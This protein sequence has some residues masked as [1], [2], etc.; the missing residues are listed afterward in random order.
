MSKFVS[1]QQILSERGVALVSARIHEMG[2][3]WRASA[4]SD[5]GIDGHVEL[6]DPG[7]GAATNEL[8]LV[9]VKSTKKPANETA[10]TFDLR[11]EKRDLEYWL[12]GN[13]PVILIVAIPDRGF[14]YWL[15]VRHRAYDEQGKLRLVQ[16]F[17]K[18]HDILEVGARE[19]LV[20]LV[21]NARP[22]YYEAPR[23]LRETLVSNLLPV[24]KLPPRLYVAPTEHRTRQAVFKI[25][26]ES[27]QPYG[28]EWLLTD[29]TIVSAHDLTERP[30]SLV[31]DAGAVDDFA[32]EEWSNSSDEARVRDFVQLLNACLREKTKDFLLYHHERPTDCLYFR[33]ATAGIAR[34]VGYHAA[35]NKTTRE[36]VMV[37]KRKD[38]SISF[39]R[40]NAIKWRFFAWEA[41]WFLEITPTY[42]FTTDGTR[43]LR[44]YEDLLKG[45][46][47]LE[48]NGAV[49]GQFQM[50]A[51]LLREDGNMIESPYP[52]LGLG[53]P[54]TF[55]VDFGFNENELSLRFGEEPIDD[56]DVAQ[57]GQNQ[58]ELV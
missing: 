5:A 51:A 34:V 17:D 52:L 56:D 22:G 27:G 4:T 45:I 42:F 48:N 44:W 54:I 40:H 37:K 20:Q 1:E 50:W 21:R 43:P 33:P 53:K 57:D 46:K 3:I 16:R 7:S 41:Q 14:A 9:Q 13:V 30:Y 18:S 26:K 35:K 29:R 55:D 25:L 23:P 2:F 11:V 24:Q 31:C 47:R 15:S 8:V 12:R 36:V 58:F 32:V 49:L 38:G 39:V 28:P 10:T 19:S 6:R